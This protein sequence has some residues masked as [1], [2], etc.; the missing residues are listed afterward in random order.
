MLCAH[1]GRAAAYCLRMS[2]ACCFGAMGCGEGGEGGG[3]RQDDRSR[4]LVFAAWPRTG[5]RLFVLATAA[6]GCACSSA[7]AASFSPLSAYTRSKQERVHL[8]FVWL[9]TRT[10]ATLSHVQ[11]SASSYTVHG[12]YQVPFSLE[13]RGCQGRRG[14]VPRRSPLLPVGRVGAPPGERAWHGTGW[15]G[16]TTTAAPCHRLLVVCVSCFDATCS[17]RA[18]RMLFCSRASPMPVRGRNESFSFL[19]HFLC[20]KQAG[21]HPPP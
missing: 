2:K 14:D 17:S 8:A 5:E 12:G 19:L 18:S 13:S 20:G 6:V 1:T 4:V 9:N 21:Q 3:G 7:S 16:F 10:S 15:H 11:I